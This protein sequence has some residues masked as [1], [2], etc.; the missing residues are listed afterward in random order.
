MRIYQSE[1]DAGV[2][3]QMNESGGS[4]V[5][6]TA[7]AQ[8]SDTI[9]TPELLKSAS[10]VHSVE[11]LLGN[12]QD[13]LSL[14]VSILV[15]TGWNLNDDI[16]VPSE[17]WKARLSPLHKPINDQHDAKRILGH[18]VQSRV[19][20][21]SGN[22]VISDDD[23]IPEE[24]DIEVAGVLYRAFPEL[25]ERIDEII[26]KA[27]T[28]E[29]FVSMEAWFPDF[30]YGIID[31]NTGTTKLV[32]RTEATAFLTKH[33]RIYGGSGQ[34]Q[35]YRVG[36]VLRDFVFGA[37]GF[38]DEPA[39][40]ESVIKVAASKVAVPE[41][42]VTA[43]INEFLERGVEDMDEKQLQELE[44]VKAALDSKEKEIAE[45]QK[46]VEEF[47][48]KDYAGQIEVLTANVT[49]TAE[50]VKTVEAEKVDMQKKLD[51]ALV[52]VEKSEAELENIRK[53]EVARERLA[54]LLEVKVVDDQV[55]TLAELQ[56]MTD[57]TF[58]IVLK[59]AGE[60]RVDV[61]VEA[62]E[63]AEQ[64]EASLETVKE[65]DSANFDVKENSQ[66]SENNKW[67][68]TAHALCGKEN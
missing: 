59:Y 48:S 37:Q 36:R 54:K 7:Q 22:E 29:I 64:A 32:D 9:S 39:N 28:G 46:T 1:K 68:S 4:S 44:E 3:I 43:E 49:E 8:V 51:E 42:F 53:T 18:I 62:V 57:E 20:D 63:E 35:G 16:F 45:L 50:K 15:S 67:K 19:L 5:F 56:D 30:G 6:L 17:V 2:D 58:A 23:N 47:N 13:D 65:D 26:A 24:F 61:V 34:Y 27:K 52:R 38:V 60:K 31:S 14:I 11:E 12:E 40:P 25:R 33:L 21:K 10:T 41:I 55:A 66:E